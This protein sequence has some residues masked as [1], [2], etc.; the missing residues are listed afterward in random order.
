MAT[1]RERY[2]AVAASVALAGSI[3]IAASANVAAAAPSIAPFCR[4]RERTKR[5]AAHTKKVNYCSTLTKKQRTT[6]KKQLRAKRLTNKQCSAKA[7]SL[8]ITAQK[9]AAKKRLRPQP[10]LQLRLPFRQCSGYRPTARLPSR[11][12]KQP[13]DSR[14]GVVGV[15]AD[16]KHEF[17]AQ[18]AAYAAA[19]GAS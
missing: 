11:R 7:R 3:G 9:A 13:S 16:F 19:R 5:Q 4:R 14:R 18:D 17:P 15:F 10:L 6:L 2:V 8:K 1:I 12:P